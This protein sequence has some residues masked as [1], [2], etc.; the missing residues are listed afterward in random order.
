ME[1]VVG[2]SPDLS[3]RELGAFGYI[4]RVEGEEVIGRDQ[5]L[6]QRGQQVRVWLRVKVGQNLDQIGHENWTTLTSH[7]CRQVWK[8]ECKCK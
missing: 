2:E 1:D 4:K 8:L 7:A 5:R 6:L 3:W